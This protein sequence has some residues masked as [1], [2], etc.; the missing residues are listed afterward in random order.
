MN[1]LPTT[2]PFCE[3]D[4]VVQELQCRQCDIT[5]RG[6]FSPGPISE[7]EE[8]QLPVLRRLARLSPEQ[9]EF[10]EAF[11]RCE[12]KLN[13]LE[14]EIGLSYPTLRSRLNDVVRDLGFTPREED[15]SSLVDRRKVLDDLQ[16]GRI[17]AADATR[18][19]RGER[20]G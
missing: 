7:F 12:G 15:R 16:G 1:R 3:G 10:L 17:S 20:I 14:E 9:L 8:A 19:L 18:L 2:C 13:R 6:H 4:V 5:I 11:I